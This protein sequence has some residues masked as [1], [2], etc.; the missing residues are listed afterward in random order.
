MKDRKRCLLKR[1]RLNDPRSALSLFAFTDPLWFEVYPSSVREYHSISNAC[2]L[3]KSH[4]TDV[5]GKDA[6]FMVAFELH[7]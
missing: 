7:C 4:I 6:H 1:L 2:T 5:A 3:L